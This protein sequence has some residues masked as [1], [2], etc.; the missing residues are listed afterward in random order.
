M[1]KILSAVGI[2]V[3]S[4]AGAITLLSVGTLANQPIRAKSM[5]KNCEFVV[6]YKFTTERVP[7]TK[8]IVRPC[9]PGDEQIEKIVYDRLESVK[10]LITK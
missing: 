2:I 3:V 9:K 1:K 4:F 7:F 6:E 8:E 5:E 10:H